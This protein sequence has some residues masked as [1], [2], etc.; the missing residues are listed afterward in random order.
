MVVR[1][2]NFAR[3]G[4]SPKGCEE[5]SCD[6]RT[7]GS[8]ARANPA[9]GFEVERR[10]EGVAA[11]RVK[12]DPQ[13]H[14]VGQAGATDFGG[15]YLEGVSSRLRRRPGDRQEVESV[16]VLAIGSTAASVTGRVLRPSIAPYFA[17]HAQRYG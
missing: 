7:E 16:V 13:L 6:L 17:C 9:I 10:L 14:L 12:N 3:G 11:V 1:W 4:A 2:Q 15:R 8:G 5:T